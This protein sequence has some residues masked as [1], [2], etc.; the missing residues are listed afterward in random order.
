LKPEVI[1]VWLERLRARVSSNQPELLE[2]YN[3]YAGE[4]RFGR[5][6]IEPNLQQLKDGAHLLEVGAGALILSTQLVREG[7][8]VTALE[9]TGEGFSHFDR[10]RELVME[11]ATS[12]G[13]TPELLAIPAEALAIKGRFHFAFSI[14]VMEHVGDVETVIHRVCE[15]LDS[16]GEYRF[17]CPNYLFPY[18][19]HFDIP[20]LFSKRLTECCFS[21]RIHNNR[22]IPDPAGTW[23]SLNWITVAAI[24][25][26]VRNIPGAEV[27]FRRDLPATMIVRTVNDPVFSARRSPWLRKLLGMAV[28]LGLHRLAVAI[29]ARLQPVIDCT[30]VRKPSCSKGL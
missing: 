9:P 7:F 27:S 20:T 11:E 6:Y 25:A 1:E 5:A 12:C 2:L 18:E 30:L 14:N 3:T 26:V 29:P 19:P 4:A 8:K 10:L 16:E 21:H 13:C 15:S 17:T 23:R 22:N 24:L 28:G